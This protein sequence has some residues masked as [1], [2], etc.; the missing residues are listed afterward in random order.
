MK[1]FLFVLGLL[2]IFNNDFSFAQ[3]DSLLKKGWNPRGVIGVGLSQVALSNWA[4]GGENLIS[5][6]ANSDFA[7]HYVNYPWILRNTLLFSLGSTKTG[8]NSFQTNENGLALENVLVRKIGWAV[9][10]YISNLIRSTILNGYDYSGDPAIQT[11]GFF[12]PGYVTQSIGFIFERPFFSTRL[13]LAFQETFANKFR[14]YTDDLSTT[15]TN[16]AFKFQTGIESVT[17]LSVTPAANVLFTSRLRLFSG[18]ETLGIWDVGWDNTITARVNDF[19]T[20]NLNA[21]V[22]YEKAQSP[23]TQLKEGLNLAISY[24]VF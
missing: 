23:Y 5:I 3:H 15:E 24:S 19:L 6:T 2:I 10:P 12:D 17:G 22:V 9:D 20:V 18:F 16:E 13:G 14:Q 21:L 8:S 1:R 7:D 11:S 4:K